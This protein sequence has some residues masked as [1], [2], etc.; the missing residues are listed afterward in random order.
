MSF[1]DAGS[2]QNCGATSST[3]W[4]WFSG[5]YIVE[6]CAWPKASYKVLSIICGVIPNRD[7][8][9]RS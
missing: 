9:S 3:T 4:Y 2:C 1:K 8:V 6:T 5:V 7:A